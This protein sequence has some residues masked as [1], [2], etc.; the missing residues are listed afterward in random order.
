VM[1]ANSV[2]AATANHLIFEL[3]VL[4]SG[5]F[6]LQGIFSFAAGPSSPYRHRH[7]T[8]KR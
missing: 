2:T 5:C 6:N 4:L 3:I 1:R 8:R 7:P